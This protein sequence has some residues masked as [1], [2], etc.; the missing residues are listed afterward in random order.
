MPRT[1]I[2]LFLL[3]A[4][5]APAMGQRFSRVEDIRSNISAYY[6]YVE[7]GTATIQVYVLGT[8]RHPGLYELTDGTD[9]G[10]LLAL[11][12]G[13]VLDVRQRSSR[14]EVTLRLFRP[15]SYRSEPLYESR[16]DDAVTRPEA[17]P[18]LREGDV[19]TIEV[20]EKQRLNWRDAFTVLGGVSALAIAV[21]QI[22]TGRR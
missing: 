9:L 20:V 17:Y 21:R 15:G 3:F 13:P 5:S 6:F 10:R 1:L 2:V 16:L 7:A 12:G 11:S 19:I 14:R 18:V 22:I 8:V 4:T